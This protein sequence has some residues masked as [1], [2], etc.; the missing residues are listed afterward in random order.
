MGVAKVR[1]N[2]FKNDIAKDELRRIPEIFL[3]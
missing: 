3:K 2:E 1:F